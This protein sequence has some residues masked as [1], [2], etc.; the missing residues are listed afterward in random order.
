M[1]KLVS[2]TAI[3]GAVIGWWGI[4][5]LTSK[6]YADQPGAVAFLYALLFLALTATLAPP[7]AYLNR[8]FAPEA[9]KRDPLRFLRHSAWGAL[10]LSSWAWLQMQRAFNLGFALIIGLI[11][12]ALEVLIARTRTGP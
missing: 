7:A 1:G 12:I 3:V 2:I 6:V 8:R 9:V 10:C 11:F 4:Y 5:E